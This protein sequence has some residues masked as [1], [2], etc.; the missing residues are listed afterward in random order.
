[1]RLLGN[2]TTS[3]FPFNFISGISARGGEL[4]NCW[5]RFLSWIY[6]SNQIRISFSLKPVDLLGGRLLTMRGG[7]SSFGPPVGATGCAHEKTVKTRMEYKSHST[8][9][10]EV[11]WWGNSLIDLKG[12]PNSYPRFCCKQAKVRIIGLPIGWSVYDANPGWLFSTTGGTEF[13]SEARKDGLKKSEVW[14]RKLNTCL[15]K[16]WIVFVLDQGLVIRGG[17]GCDRYAAPGELCC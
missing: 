2:G 6:S 16:W 5:V 3:D 15:L 13:I 8:R 9:L 12:F 1:M 11:N 7:F 4:R 10:W 14:K 17:H